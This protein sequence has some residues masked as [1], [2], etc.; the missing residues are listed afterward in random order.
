MKGRQNE[1]KIGFGKQLNSLTL[2]SAVLLVFCFVFFAQGAIQIIRDTLWQFSDPPPLVWHFFLFLSLVLSLICIDLHLKPY[3]ADKQNF[4]PQKLL[5]T[6]FKKLK[7][8]SDTS[9]TPQTHVLFEWPP[10]NKMVSTFH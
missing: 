7:I 4:S 6:V 9:L 1:D 10:K 3:I 2:Q 5:K 8:L